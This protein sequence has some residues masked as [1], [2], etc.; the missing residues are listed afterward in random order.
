LVCLFAQQVR[1][2]V[3]RVLV[4]HD[5]VEVGLIPLSS[6]DETQQCVEWTLF[7]DAVDDDHGMPGQDGHRGP[8][9]AAE[10]D[11]V[12]RVRRLLWARRFTT[13]TARHVLA[14]NHCGHFRHD[15]ALTAVGGLDHPEHHVRP[16]TDDLR[17]KIAAL[18]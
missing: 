6:P 7:A 4:A 17:R 9:V 12:C 14:M 5:S 16:D 11:Q 18:D 2:A 13:L 3:H 1:S 10:E 15:R 8:P